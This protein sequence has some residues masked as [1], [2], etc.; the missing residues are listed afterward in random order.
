MKN[1]AII[2]TLGPDNVWSFKIPT[3][4]VEDDGMKDGEGTIINLCRGSRD[5]QSIPRQEGVFTETLL[6]VCLAYL[7]GVNKGELASRDTSIAITHIEDALLRIRKRAQDRANRG[8][9][10]TYNK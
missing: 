7:Q 6:E 2:E 10:G 5:N 3:Y 4:K 9:Q 1:P 8:V